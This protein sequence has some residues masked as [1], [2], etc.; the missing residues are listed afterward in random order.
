MPDEA[1]DLDLLP[2]GAHNN[3]NNNNDDDD[4][5]ANDDHHHGLD[6][7]IQPPTPN[8]DDTDTNNN[9]NAPSTSRLTRVLTH[10]KHSITPDPSRLPNMLLTFLHP[11]ISGVGELIRGALN[12]RRGPGVAVRPTATDSEERIRSASRPRAI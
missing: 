11:E 6:T 10:I 4:D 1:S 5:D 7:N 3:N 8:N 9:N 2:G 12:C